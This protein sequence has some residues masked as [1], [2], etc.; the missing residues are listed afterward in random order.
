M[1]VHDEGYGGDAGPTLEFRSDFANR[2]PPES[3]PDDRSWGM[4]APN[5]QK[6]GEP[7]MTSGANTPGQPI[8]GQRS[9]FGTGRGPVFA[10]V[11]AYTPVTR[12]SEAPKQPTIEPS[13]PAYGDFGGKGG[14]ETASR[15]NPAGAPDF[16]NI[17]APAYASPKETLGTTQAYSS[18]APSSETYRQSHSGQTYPSA[19]EPG[20][21]FSAPS[22]P[23]ESYAVEANPSGGPSWGGH[24]DRGA[25]REAEPSQANPA[26]NYSTER[27][28]ARTEQGYQSGATTD[29][30]RPDHGFNA[31]GANAGFAGFPEASFPDASFPEASFTETSFHE[32]A[33]PSSRQ[34]D[35]NYGDG[36][37]AEAALPSEAFSEQ[38][39][40]PFEEH[41][42]F[43]LET[44]ADFNTE[45]EAYSPAG[46][47]GLDYRSQAPQ[48]EASQWQERGA[49]S[50]RA[51]QTF[52]AL[53]DQP[54]QIALG[55]TQR[56]NQNAQGFYEDEQPD[57]DFLDE[58][59][60]PDGGAGAMAQSVRK[61]GLKGRSIFMVGSALLGAVALGGAL[62][63]AY[64]QS[65]GAMSGGEPPLVQADNRPV[66]E[67]P[68]QP[69][70]KNFPNKNKLIY[71]RLQNGD[72]P[73]AERVVPRQEELAMPALPGVSPAPGFPAGAAPMAPPPV[74]TVDDPNVAGG[75]PRR[76]KTL[77]VRPD[78]TLAEPAPAAQQMA[79]AD[80][81]GHPG[82]A[83]QAPQAAVAMP[84]P[85]ASP[86]VHQTVAAVPAADPQPVAA[87]PAAAPKAK[88]APAADAEP[89]A[90]KPSKYL[91]QVGSKQDQTEA[92]ATFA[93]LQQKYPT[94]L[95]S[96]RPMVQKADL[97]AKGVWYRL[98]IG[99][100]PD[101][102]AATKLCGELKSQGL[103]DCLVMAAQ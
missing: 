103:P 36:R 39:R 79:A 55:P 17:A 1:S 93:D 99:P 64:K 72:Q 53:Y 41:E 45:P 42:P 69:G 51:L 60:L 12:A 90:A 91:V 67:A 26:P 71:E 78:G 56:P 11:P 31:S 58:A 98:R 19:A 48:D 101:K 96:Y 77:T 57:A 61:A 94:L 13:L 29:Q 34:A 59:Q 14:A 25:Q 3:A 50:G 100:I 85:A 82:G 5:A 37:F 35:A 89:E 38:P 49:P 76:V 8:M 92:L 40:A 54:P 15:A 6:S 73:E 47:G 18:Q 22:Y 68:E 84:A 24:A 83:P 63:F 28:Q 10:Q 30:G 75:G 32:A 7:T 87:L 62:A 2:Q 95:A 86:A 52:D 4:T 66:K 97:G 23:A 43:A 88:P 80:L 65:G 20:Q 21:G 9:I 74:A 102:T 16:P 46:P 81:A 44:P 27:Y 33:A 70:G